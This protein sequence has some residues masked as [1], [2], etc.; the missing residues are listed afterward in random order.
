V[1]ARTE[2]IETAVKT[3]NKTGENGEGKHYF[4]KDLSSKGKKLRKK[5]WRPSAG[6]ARGPPCHRGRIK[7]ARGGFK[8]EKKRGGCKKNRPRSP[9]DRQ[10]TP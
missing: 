8:M 6:E 1:D 3:T 5:K 10:R 9:G 2:R 7:K 4:L